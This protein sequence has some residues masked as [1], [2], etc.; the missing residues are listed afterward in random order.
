MTPSTRSAAAQAVLRRHNVHVLGTGAPTIMFCNGF[1]CAQHVWH[2]LTPALA[3]QH[4]LVLFDQVGVG[5][6]ERTIA[7]PARYA[8]LQGYAQDVIDICRALDLRNVVLV[9]HSAGATIALLAAQQA[10][11]CIARLVLLAMSPHYL[12]EPGYY[13]GFEQADL[14]AVLAEMRTNYPAWAATFS[15]MIIGQHHAPTLSH[16]LVECASQADQ[17]LAKR[18]VELVFLGDFR[19]LLPQVRQPVLLL[20]CT[21]DAAVPVEVNQYLLTHLPL[22]ALVQL[23]ATGHSPHLTAPAEVLAAI[24]QFGT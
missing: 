13:G 12:N 11:D 9:G 14:E 22:V 16:E 1:N 7:D 18:V 20:Q 8:T 15:T 5:K 4:Q 2:F 19:A 10:P 6:A 3:K 17:A 21:D 23:R 24:Q